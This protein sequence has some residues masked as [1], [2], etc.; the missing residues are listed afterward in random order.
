MPKKRLSMRKIREILRLRYEHKRSTREI[1]TSISASPS[2]VAECL[3]RARVAGLKW[4]VGDDLDDA[5]L[6]SMLYH[7]PAPASDRAQPDFEHIHREMRR[8]GVTLMLLWQEYKA[9]HPD[10]GY[11]YTQF[12]EWYRRYQRKLDVV[13]RQ[14]HR[15]GEKGFVDYSGDGIP[16]VDPRNGKVREAQ[17]FVMTLGASSFTF[18][19]VQESQELRHWVSGHIH[20][21]EYFHGVPAITIPD[22]TKTAVTDPCRYE[23]DINPTYLDL[24]RHYDT[25]ILPARPR[26]PRD[27]AKVEN[28]VL[29]A[30]RWILAKL[31]NHRFFSVAQA[32]EAVRDLV[33]QLNDRKFQKMDTT[34]RKLYEELDRPA[35]RPLP[36][37]RWEFA[38]WSKRKVNIDYHVE[39]DKHFYSVPYQ[40]VKQTVEARR[41]SMTVEFFHRDRRVASH[42]RSY[43]P[44]FS[45]KREHMPKSH[46]KYLEWTPSRILQ[47][48]GETGPYTAELAKHILESRPHPQ[49]GYRSCLG[50][51]RLGK[52]FGKERLEAACQRAIELRAYSYK[53]IKSIL[54]NGLDRQPLPAQDTTTTTTPVDHAN[55]RGSDYYH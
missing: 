22:N 34:R 21:Y 51:L 28:A 42:P 10:D 13:L 17:L 3:G 55:I 38:E 4:P 35:L 15:S 24:A 44:G 23:P 26:K 41:T 2:T 40:L 48:A 37:V 1:A 30:Q 8:K 46:Q 19:E 39:V 18:A 20:A 14:E 50:I 45:T 27:K 29:V 52:G 47:W 6:E 25:A 5:K 7:A 31:R 33:D 49:Q 54:E 9:A 11:Q 43:K 32:N 36:P 12:C 53:N 16:I